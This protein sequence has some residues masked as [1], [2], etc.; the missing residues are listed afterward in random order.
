VKSRLKTLKKCCLFSGNPAK[1][2]TLP[3]LQSA[4]TSAALKRKIVTTADLSQSQ[5]ENRTV[6]IVRVN[7]SISI[8]PK[9]PTTATLVTSSS[10]TLSTTSKPGFVVRPAQ[11]TTANVTKTIVVTSNAELLKKQLEESQ[12]MVEQFREQLRQ[13]EVENARLKKLLEKSDSS[14]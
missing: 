6:K 14:P 2:T 11:T 13:Q 7:P 10:A 1:L 4:A 5:S 12:K 9:K 8:Q 3:Q